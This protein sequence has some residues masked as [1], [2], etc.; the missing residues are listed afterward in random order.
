MTALEGRRFNSACGEGMFASIAPESLLTAPAEAG[1]LEVPKLALGD[2]FS[3][4]GVYAPGPGELRPRKS[5]TCLWE[6]WTLLASSRVDLGIVHV[7]FD[8]FVDSTSKGAKAATSKGPSN[9]GG[10]LAATTWKP[11]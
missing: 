6:M 1:L 2:F 9:S 10:K 8:G 4:C 5:V 7:G 11:S 3:L